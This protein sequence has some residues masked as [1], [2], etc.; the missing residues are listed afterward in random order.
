MVVYCWYNARQLSILGNYCP[1]ETSTPIPCPKGTYGPD[2]GAVSI[3][4]CLVCPPHHYCPRAGLVVPLPC[5][6]VAQQPLSGQYTCICPGEGQSFQVTKWFHL[7][8]ECE[9]SVFK[10]PMAL[11]ECAVLL[12][13]EPPLVHFTYN[14]FG[15][16]FV[17]YAP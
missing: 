3:N 15:L 14:C 1:L 12:S 5:G 11:C 7:T 10:C 8:T 16:F 6:P 4:N 2:A 13:H 17:P 9:L